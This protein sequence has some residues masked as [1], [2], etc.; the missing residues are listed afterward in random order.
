MRTRFRVTDTRDC[1]C[2]R[3]GRY[4]YQRDGYD[5]FQIDRTTEV[6][7][8]C[9]Y[10][11]QKCEMCGKGI[12]LSNDDFKTDMNE[13]FFCMECWQKISGIYKKCHRCLADIDTEYDDFSMDKDGNFLCE[14]CR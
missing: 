6:C 8:D 11:F 3:C 7:T 10:D 1:L 2:E 13:N 5:F 9:A 14:E 12:D 4:R